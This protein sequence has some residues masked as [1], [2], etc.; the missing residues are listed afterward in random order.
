MEWL[1]T[2]DLRTL[3]LQTLSSCR[4]TQPISCKGSS[5]RVSP[6]EEIID[7]SSAAP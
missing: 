1:A 2:G 3:T 4:P 7:A 5:W 6:L